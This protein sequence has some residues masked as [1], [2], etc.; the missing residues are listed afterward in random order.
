MQI[1]SF[2][3]LLLGVF[4]KVLLGALFLVFWLYDR[5][6]TCFAWW[7]GGFFF[8]ALAVV[9]FLIYGVR[10]SIE[11]IGAGVAAL[12]AA[13]GLAWQGARA[14]D[15][16]RPM[17]IPVVLLPAIWLGLCLVPGFLDN[18]RAR[19]I[20]SSLLIAP[21]IAMSGIEYWRG[22][23]EPLL[24]RWPAIVLFGT[25]S[26]MF[27]SRIAFLDVLPFP[28]GALP[29]QPAYVAFFNLLAFFHVLLLTVLMVALVKE[30]I[31]LDQR[32]KA[33]TDPLTGA[34]NRRAFIGR[35]TRLLARHQYETAPLCLMF[36]DLD[37]F[38]SLNDRHGHAGGDD[39]L[40]HFVAIVQDNIRPTD[41]LFRYGGEE[42]C[43]LLPYTTAEQAHRVAERIRH[44]FE[45]A[46]VDV[47]GVPVKA[48]VSLGIAST[49]VFGH[50]LDT[51]IRRA[52]TAVY[53]AKRAGRNRVE[54]ATASSAND[55]LP[56]AGEGP[57]G[58]T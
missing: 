41:F 33:Q 26:L 20:V 28:F 57:V 4:I 7:S 44:K 19:V 21:L 32:R 35:G 45:V 2:T 24:S 11:A 3:V 50:D 18:L 29:A 53:A 14:F 1:D 13:F 10:G 36:L 15:G 12:I 54:V 52:D 22:R 27:A 37:H 9:V 17:L 48:T 39:V 58:A 30:R 49:E 23:D 47:A 40:M 5:R 25:F 6:S 55:K 46:I 16:R 34:L 38:K 51:L 42:F 43:C 31:E 56:I 8:G